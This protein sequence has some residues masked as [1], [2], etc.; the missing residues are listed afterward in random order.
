[1]LSK[2]VW[3]ELSLRLVADTN[4]PSKLNGVGVVAAEESNFR[5]VGMRQR[6]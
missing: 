5:K 1:M 2:L 4:N 6:A 3:A